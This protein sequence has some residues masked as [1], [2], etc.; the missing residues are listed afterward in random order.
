MRRRKADEPPTTPFQAY[1]RSVWEKTKPTLQ[2]IN[3]FL[4]VPMWAA[5][6]SIFI[7]MIQPLQE[8]LSKAEPFV[9]AVKGAGQCSSEP[10]HL[11]IIALR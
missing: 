2:A 3:A 6:I 9:K 5:L 7:A 8:A 11:V 1:I 10:F 4:T